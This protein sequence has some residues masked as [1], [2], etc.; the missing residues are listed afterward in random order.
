MM[1]QSGMLLYH[2]SYT[3]ILQID[4]EQCADGKDFGKGFYLSDDLAQARSFIP[5]A[6][7]KAVR[8]NIIPKNT[9]RG[10]VSVFRY[11]GNDSSFPVYEFDTANREWL[12]FVSLNRR[13]K[14]AS[15]LKDKVNPAALTAEIIIGKIA[16][17][18]TNPT[19]T[20]WLSGLYGPV[21]QEQSAN[22]AVELLLPNRLKDQY[23]FRTQQA[24]NC[25]T[26]EEVYNYDV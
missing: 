21:E 10:Y 4:L 17:D 16:N 5:R 11:I 13:E 12:W 3:K 14:M 6:I 15:I 20:A 8:N 23:C 9:H 1:L 2:G 22:I 25:L 19:I 26:L 18:T 24:V 7:Q